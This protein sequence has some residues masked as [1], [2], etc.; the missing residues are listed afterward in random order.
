MQ[1][2]YQRH[3][4]KDIATL[5]ATQRWKAKVLNEVEIMTGLDLDGDGDVG[6]E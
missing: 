5:A 6:V 1:E 3:Q 4:S 2:F